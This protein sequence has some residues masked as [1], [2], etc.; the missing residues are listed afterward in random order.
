MMNA[1]PTE[2]A[3]AGEAEAAFLP[4][5][6]LASSRR[7]LWLMLLLSFAVHAGLAAAVLA[8]PSHERV[9]TDEASH[10]I[11]IALVAAP[12]PPKVEA[13]PTPPRPVPPKVEKPVVKKPVVKQKTPLPLPE[14]KKKSE[15]AV[16]KRA[17]VEPVVEAT[18]PPATAAASANG[19]AAIST[20]ALQT[21]AQGR[22]AYGRLVWKKIAEAKP[23]G[24]HQK[25]S[26]DVRFVVTAQG[27]LRSVEIF[28]ST[29]HAELEALARETLA[30][31][32]PFP[33]PPEELGPEDFIFEIPFNFQ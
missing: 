11:S 10:V 23:A 21:R 22:A 27:K 26:V 2:N 19:H 24:L 16:V 25:G 31:A 3:F 4:P 12:S 14:K 5:Q 29:G 6:P 33:P 15:V 17:P 13:E 9:G 32:A 8:V 1:R 30:R 18:P 28:N 20:V 7:L